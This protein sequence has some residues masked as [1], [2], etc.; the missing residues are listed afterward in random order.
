[1]SEINEKNIEN[2]I[3]I[4]IKS[5]DIKSIERRSD[6]FYT[7]KIKNN[8]S[9]KEWTLQKELSEFRQFYSKVYKLYKNLPPIPSE[10]LFKINSLPVIDKIKCILDKFLKHCCN[11]LD[12]LLNK[13]FISFIELE[14]NSPELVG[15]QVTLIKKS[16]KFDLSVINFI[17]CKN[18]IVIIF[19]DNDFVSRD[20]IKLENINLIRDHRK[21]PKKPLGSLSIYQYENNTYELKKISEKFYNIQPNKLLFDEKT[22]IICV[23]TDDGKIYIYKPKNSGDYTDLVNITILSF[24]SDRI[25]G[26]FLKDM[27]IYSCSLD[28]LFFV[29]DLNNN[30]FSKILI[31]NGSFGFTNLNY[32]NNFFITSE[33]DGV[34]RVFSNNYPPKF[35]RCF[36]SKSL[37]NINCL[38]CLNGFIFTGGDDG[39]ICIINLINK[40]GYIKINEIYS[41][42]L[43]KIKVNSFDYNSKNNE[44]IICLEDGKIIIWDIFSL[45]NKYCFE[46]HD[47]FSANHIFFNK[48]KNILVSGGNDKCLKIWKIPEKWWNFENFNKETKNFNN[49]EN[50]DELDICSDEDE[51]NG[52]NIKSKK[53]II[54]D[55][56]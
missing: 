9:N 48:D 21:N 26:L 2:I 56:Y 38:F 20:D 22:E 39:K 6:Y 45:K 8:N 50:G 37:F 54:T 1:M 7:I 53:R 15:N 29:T 19:A 44:I 42:E 30:S 23:G 40:N 32:M 28:T 35:L 36:Q 47:G 10:T 52:W 12:I 13:D 25:T 3:T 51:L 27:N 55:I 33:E 14:K 34:I 4:K 41:F 5:Y 31:F 18:I 43:D 17:I 46:P 49:K 24:H 11:R 16:Q